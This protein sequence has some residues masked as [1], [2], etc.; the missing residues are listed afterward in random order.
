MLK[1][2][3]RRSQRVDEEALGLEERVLVVRW[4]YSLGSAVAEEIIS[5]D[6]E[7]DLVELLESVVKRHAIKIV[8]RTFSR[9]RQTAGGIFEHEK[10]SIDLQASAYYLQLCRT[11]S[12][13]SCYLSLQS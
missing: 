6:E 9:L 4:H 8:G 12:Q 3:A 2:I 7:A 5:I 13:C 1:A 10:I 11:N